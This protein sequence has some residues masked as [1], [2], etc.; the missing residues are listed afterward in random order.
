MSLSS[1]QLTFPSPFPSPPPP[2]LS[3][4]VESVALLCGGCSTQRFLL[5][6]ISSKPLR[7][8]DRCYD[9]LTTAQISKEELV[10]GVAGVRG[11]AEVRGVARVSGVAEVS[12]VAV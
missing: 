1:L 8:C 12:G 6:Q 11:V 4:T 9:K 5:P 3:T 10:R 7:V 2:S